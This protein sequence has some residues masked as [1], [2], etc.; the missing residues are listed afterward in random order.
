MNRRSRPLPVMC[1]NGERL[2]E[3]CIPY[4]NCKLCSMLRRVKS[5][6]GH[7]VLCLCVPPEN[8]SV[9]QVLRR[10][11]RYLTF[12]LCFKSGMSAVT[13]LPP[14]VC[15]RRTPPCHEFMLMYTTF[16][17][18]VYHRRTPPCVKYLG[19]HAVI[20]LLSYVSSRASRRSRLCRLMCATGE[21]L[22][23]SSLC[24]CTPPFL[25]VYTSGEPLRASSTWAITPLSYFF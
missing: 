18:G 6:G 8:P 12:K 15:N 4:D 1:T 20:L 3:S 23:A 22:R 16:F 14:N 13:P 21:P 24:L 17:A 5:L 9:R 7:A 2:R 11:R 25:L 19:A 10:S